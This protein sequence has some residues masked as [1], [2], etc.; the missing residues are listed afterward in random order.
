[1]AVT[2]VLLLL[3]IGNIMELELD[4]ALHRGHAKEVRGKHKKLGHHCRLCPR[5]KTRID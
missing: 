4:L 5:R 3:S 1:M 2:I